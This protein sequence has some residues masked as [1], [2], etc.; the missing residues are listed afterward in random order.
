MVSFDLDRRLGELCEAI[1]EADREGDDRYGAAALRRGI[2]GDSLPPRL[3]GF[4]SIGITC[5]DEDG[6]A[7]H[8]HLPSDT[9]DN[10]DPAALER[11]HGF[12]LELIRQLDRDL[13]RVA[14]S[15]AAT[16]R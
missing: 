10:V 15:A 4:R 7:P 1:A 5:R 12:T 8:Y 16:G 11:A 14:T 3:R 13:G 9:P 6:Y 2:A